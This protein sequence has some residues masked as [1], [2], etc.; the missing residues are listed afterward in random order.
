VLHKYSRDLNGEY[1]SDYSLTG[2]KIRQS[3]AIVALEL[4]LSQRGMKNAHDRQGSR[5]PGNLINDH[6][7]IS[8]DAPFPRLGRIAGPT[9][10]RP[11]FQSLERI[12]NGPNHPHGRFSIAFCD[13]CPDRF[14]LPESAP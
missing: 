5:P 12:T 11:T 4:S 3:D 6:I 9:H 14:K 8:R 13:I 10:I 1:R 2:S 7:G